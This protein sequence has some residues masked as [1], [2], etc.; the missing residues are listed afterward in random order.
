MPNYN[1]VILVGHL[2]RDPQLSYTPNQVAVCQFGIAVNRKRKETNEVMFIDCQAWQQAAETIQKYV[3]KGDPLLIEGRIALDQWETKDGQKR[4][5]HKVVVEGFQ[6]LGGKADGGEAPR[7]AARR[8]E[9]EPCAADEEA[10]GDLPDDDI[11]F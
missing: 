5:R 7:Q 9:P 8:P 10:H 3:K 2:T 11:P 6:F 1:K 4:S